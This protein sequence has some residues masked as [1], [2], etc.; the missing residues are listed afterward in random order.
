MII[1]FPTPAEVICTETPCPARFKATTWAS[2]KQS[3]KRHLLKE[4][5]IT[6]CRDTN[7][8]LACKSTLGNRPGYH[9]C[10]APTQASPPASQFAD[11]F[12]CAI[13]A[14]TFPSR[15]GLRNHIQAHERADQIE[16][17][18]TACLLPDRKPPPPHHPALPTQDPAEEDPQ[19][20]DPVDADYPMAAH[21]TN[22]RAIGGAAVGVETWDL[23]CR[24][25]TQITTKVQQLAKLPPPPDRDKAPGEGK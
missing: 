25:L 10:P 9:S 23:F 11:R 19:E 6:I 18:N 16:A 3:L 2:T 5:G 12:H 24:E 15:Q 13:C 7:I 8:C 20:D 22:L 4:H 21:I 1:G 14:A 17:R